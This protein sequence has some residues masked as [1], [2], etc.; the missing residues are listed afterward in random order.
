MNLNHRRNLKSAV[1]IT[2]ATEIRKDG[3]LYKNKSNT[4][5]SLRG[6][7]LLQFTVMTEKRAKR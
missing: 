1:R 7:L 4:G 5:V 3:F 6:S 2:F